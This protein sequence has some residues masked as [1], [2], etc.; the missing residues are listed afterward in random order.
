MSE[1]IPL[2]GTPRLQT[3]KGGARVTRRE[4]RIP[5]IIYGAGAEPLAISLDP[6]EIEKQAN[7]HGFYSHIFEIEV[8][9]SK[10]RVLAREVQ[11][12]LITGKPHH[13][14]FMRVSRRSRVHVEVDVR[15]VNEAASPGIAKGGIVNIALHSLD[16]VARADAMPEEIAVDLSGLEIGA[17]VHAKE[18]SLPE[19]AALGNVDPEDTVVTIAPPSGGA[20]GPAEGEGEAAEA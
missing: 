18:I 17:S 16:I 3:G 13:V 10:H 4:G 20:K 2:L 7:R 14:D 9:G 12:D 6:V 19:G 5:G 11:R 8:D 15:C 1:I